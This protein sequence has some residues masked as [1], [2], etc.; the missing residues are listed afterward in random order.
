[1]LIVFAAAQGSV[2]FGT[3]WLALRLLKIPGRMAKA[4][5]MSLSC[6]AW[7]AVTLAGYFLLGGEAGFMDGFGLVLTLCQTAIA[8]SLVYLLAWMARPGLR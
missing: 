8:S 3:A 6:A 2:V 1:M 7:L 5:A 4:I